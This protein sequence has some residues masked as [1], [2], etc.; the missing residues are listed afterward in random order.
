MNNLR[1]FIME[2][3]VVGAMWYYYYKYTFVPL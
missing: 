3:A 1:P 2:I